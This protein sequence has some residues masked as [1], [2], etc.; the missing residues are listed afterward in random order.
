MVRPRVKKEVGKHGKEGTEHRQLEKDLSP[1]GGKGLQPG[2]RKGKESHGSHDALRV[3]YKGPISVVGKK[4][5]ERSFQ[6]GAK[7]GRLNT[8]RT[9]ADVPREAADEFRARKE[10][11]TRLL[12]AAASGEDFFALKER[13]GAISSTMEKR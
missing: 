9:H 2:K 10:G 3:S 8:S 5:S 4:K 11:R 12:V 1:P 7:E 13:E 6:R